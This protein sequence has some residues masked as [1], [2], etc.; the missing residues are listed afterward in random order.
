MAVGHFKQYDFLRDK[1]VILTFDD[2]PWPANT[3]AALKALADEC[4]KATFLILV[5]NFKL[6]TAEALTADKLNDSKCQN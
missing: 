6:H 2:G 3:P 1:E 5:H 4:L